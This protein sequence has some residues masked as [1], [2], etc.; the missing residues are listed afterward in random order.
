MMPDG[1]GQTGGQKL[2]LLLVIICSHYD[3]GTTDHISSVSQQPCEV[4]TAT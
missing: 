1:E 3:Q 4:Y 2:S